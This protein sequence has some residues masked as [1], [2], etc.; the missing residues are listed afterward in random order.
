MPVTLIAKDYGY[1]AVM[2]NKLLHAFRIQYPV[3]KTWALYCDYADNGYTHT[4]VFKPKNSH[5]PISHTCWTQKGRN[6]LW[7]ASW[8]K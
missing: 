1:T 6:T 4:N 2:F 7:N 5:E 8:K 3:G